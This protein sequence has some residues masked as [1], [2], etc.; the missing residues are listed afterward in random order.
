MLKIPVNDLIF[1]TEILKTSLQKSFICFE[2]LCSLFVM[3]EIEKIIAIK[4]FIL[5]LKLNLTCFNQ[6]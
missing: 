6:I 5:F 1:S 2:N 3:Y 4:S